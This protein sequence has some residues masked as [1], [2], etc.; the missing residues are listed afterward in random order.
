MGLRGLRELGFGVA[1]APPEIA[2]AVNGEAPSPPVELRS[3][4]SDAVPSGDV[5][6]ASLGASICV[7][8]GGAARG[9]G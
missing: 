6:F 3:A 2:M 9:E 5:A 1:G 4:A 7:D 8:V